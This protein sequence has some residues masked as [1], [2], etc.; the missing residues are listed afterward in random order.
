MTLSIE[1]LRSIKTII[2]HDVCPDGTASALILQDAL[3]ENGLTVKFIQYGTEAMAALQPE[4]GM[5]FCDVHPNEDMAQA[6]AD[7]GA[8]LLDHHRTA[9]H[10]VKLF[11]DNGVY[12]AEP[13]VSGATL[14]YREVWLP[15]V[16]AKLS[17]HHASKTMVE[18]IA[19]LAGI[20]DTW[21]KT[22]PQWIEACHQSYG[23]MFLP[24]EAFIGSVS[25]TLSPPFWSNLMWAGKVQYEKGLRRVERAVRDAYRFTSAKGTRVAVFEG[26]KMTSDAAE[27][28]SDIDLIVG[29]DYYVDKGIPKAVFSTRSRTT[30]DCGSFCKAQ[31]GGGHTKAAGFNVPNPKQDP[32]SIVMERVNAF[33]G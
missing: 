6:F 23:L 27:V 24:Q 11:G 30:F 29:F 14:A 7:A 15:A 21:Q 17:E 28:A 31:G 3:A 5:I 12:S 8:I 4:P 19:T 1:K 22:D 2:T 13:G 18:R 20:R 26:V 32:W 16:E 9:E 33:E 10:V 25:A